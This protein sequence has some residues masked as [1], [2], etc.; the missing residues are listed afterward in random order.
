MSRDNYWRRENFCNFLNESHNIDEY[1]KQFSTDFHRTLIF[2]TRLSAL[3]ICIARVIDKAFS[4]FHNCDKLCLIPLP[5]F[6]PFPFP[7]FRPFLS[8][9][10]IAPISKSMIAYWKR[11]K[12][13]ENPIPH[14]ANISIVDE[15]NLSVRKWTGETTH[16]KIRTNWLLRH[17]DTYKQTLEIKFSNYICQCLFCSGAFHALYFPSL[18]IYSWIFIDQC[19]LKRIYFGVVPTSSNSSK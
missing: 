3:V 10:P 8:F 13:K 11:K 12:K 18:W 19:R 1:R 4:A 5:L 7:S 9:L 15:A 2:F 17:A 14:V 16:Q 6:R